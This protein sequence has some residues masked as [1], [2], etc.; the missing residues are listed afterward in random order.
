MPQAS[1][2]AGRQA[3]RGEKRSEKGSARR[4]HQLREHCCRLAACLGNERHQGLARLPGP[5]SS[6]AQQPGNLCVENGGGRAKEGFER[7][8]RGFHVSA[9][10]KA[11]RGS[12]QDREK[13]LKWEISVSVGSHW[14]SV[15]RLRV[16]DGR[17]GEWGGSWHVVA[18]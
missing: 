1:K 3:G 17:I 10:G 5:R 2:Q 6:D 9:P 14:A 12:G 16:E 15:L 4:R 7:L 8:S 13:N 18:D 11:V